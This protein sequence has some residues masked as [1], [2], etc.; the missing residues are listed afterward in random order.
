MGG[1][2]ERIDDRA[3]VQSASAH[4]QDRP[5]VDVEPLCRQPLKHRNGEVDIW[6]CDID[7]LMRHFR[8]IGAGRLGC[9]DVHAP[10]GL[11]RVDREDD[12][13][14]SPSDLHCQRALPGCSR[15]DDRQER[16]IC[17]PLRWW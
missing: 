8:S 15:P 4:D 17:T 5:V 12:G 6:I 9:P 16:Q 3:E 11:H 10:V 2:C 13:A 1:E 14:D 7:Q